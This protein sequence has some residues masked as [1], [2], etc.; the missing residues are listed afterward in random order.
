MAIAD[1]VTL[2]LDEVERLT[3]AALRA[4]AT[5]EANARPVTDS[6]VAA[7]A[8]GLHSHG[9]MRL[10]TYCEHARCGKVDGRAQ[11]QVLSQHGG[12]I[13]V[14]AC[15]GFAHPAIALGFRRLVP[16]A[17]QNGIAAL[18]ITNS[19]NC[20]VVGHHVERLAREG[21]I[22]L[23]HVNA[24]ASI[25][26]WGGK[27]PF[28]GTNPI[29]MAAPRRAGPPLVIDQ[30]ASVV[31]R[32]EV[33]LHAQQGKAIPEG[34]ALD[35]FGKPTTDAK[36]ALGGSML[37][38]GGYKGSNIALIVEIFA[39]VLTGARFS[40]NASSFADNRGGPPRTGQLFIA[41]DPGVFVGAAFTE[42]IEALI[43]AMCSEP[44]VQLPGARRA[45]TRRQT[46]ARGITI[47]RSLY[48]DIAARAAGS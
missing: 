14:D 34:W 38:V 43:E 13:S 26:P 22:G 30:S 2:T 4:S 33:M 39:A 12:A 36:D 15:S 48:S 8:D 27:K 37:P 25:A 46:A 35:A 5:S 6:I 17:K 11:P 24:P 19:Y 23:A 42:R 16:A 45:A 44:G 41:V 21:L 10:P 1:T 28:F 40:I 29:A 9:L 3:H 32:G 31:A 7:E 20:G 47:E 18:A